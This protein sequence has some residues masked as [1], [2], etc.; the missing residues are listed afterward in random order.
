[1]V[2]KVINWTLACVYIFIN[3]LQAQTT[4]TGSTSKHFY[5]STSEASYGTGVFVQTGD[6]ITII[7]RGAFYNGGAFV[8]SPDGFGGTCDPAFGITTLPNIS[9]N[10]LIGAIG[11]SSQNFKTLLDGGGSGIYGPGFV[12][13]DFRGIANDTGEIYVGIND[14]PLYDNEGWIEISILINALE[15]T[16][17]KQGDRF[18]AG[19]IDTIKWENGVDNLIVKLLY[20]NDGGDHY[21]LIDAG[22]ESSENEYIWEVP[23]DLLTAKAMIKIEKNDNSDLLAKS[24]KFKI[25]PYLITKLDQNGEYVGYDFENDRWGFGNYEWDMWPESWYERFDYQSGI[26]PFTGTNY[27]QT[28][29]GGVFATVLRSDFTDWESFVNTFGINA[30]YLDVASA[31]YSLLAV[32]RWAAVKKQWNGTCWALAG[33]NALAFERE[34]DFINRFPDFPFFITPHSL[35]SDFMVIKSMTELYAQVYGNP[36]KQHYTTNWLTK[37]PNQTLYE[38]REILKEDQTKTRAITFWNNNGNGGHCILPFQIEQDKD[39]ENYWYIWVY[40]NSIPYDRDAFIVI[41]TVG[42]NNN[43]TWNYANW[44]N[45]GGDKKL[46]LELPA[47]TYLGT[48]TLP[49]NSAMK[50]PFILDN[51]MIDIYPANGEIIITDPFGNKTGIIK[52][53][54]IANIPGAVPIT[55]PAGRETPPDLYSLPRNNYTIELNNFSDEKVKCFIFDENKSYRFERNNAMI[56]QTD[57]LFY[58]GGLSFFNP[59]SISKEI[60]FVNIIKDTTNPDEKSFVLSSINMMQKD[61]VKILNPDDNKIDLISYGSAKEYDIELTHVSGFGTMKFLHRQIPLLQ[62]STH[63]LNPN[64]EDFAE[65]QLTIFIDENNNGTIDDTLYV[66]NEITEVKENQG[67]LIP[68]EYR[69]EQNYP[70]PF[71]PVT[72]ISYQIPTPM[73]PSQRGTLVTLKVYDILGKEVATLV[74]EEQTAGNY[75]VNFDASNLPSGVYLYQ[76]RAMPN[77][78][79]AS[80]PSTSTGQ[81][82]VDTKKMILIK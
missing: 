9:C 58:D 52:D 69:L 23:D 45:W 25:K 16:K 81:G 7:A 42:N 10:A 15:I 48:P 41:N 40:D 74:N 33:S 2:N 60:T 26:D 53:S 61:S 44:P 71:N 67:S 76:L 28:I 66:V 50:S 4:T 73:N 32:E 12:G 59:D 3:I 20:S 79:Q 31:D 49:K 13:S 65:L 34:N 27:D 77:G 64:W 1:M 21:E 38:L 5:L 54:L 63:K 18:I 80:D 56:T 55:F 70:N 78:R 6:T 24:K 72:K 30:C 29:N 22:I 39:E 82:F 36:T 51:G 47:T 14:V 17:P 8:P 75:E 62:N 46:I 19:T 37:T 11:N 35:I 43:G 68:T 57:R